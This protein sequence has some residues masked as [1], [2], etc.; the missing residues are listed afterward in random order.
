MIVGRRERF[1]IE[2]EVQEELNGWVLGRFRI[3]LCGKPIGNWDDAA[4]LS[5][6]VNWLRHFATVPQDRY[7]PSLANAPA[8]EVFRA[9]YDPVMGPGDLVAPIEDAFARFHISY[10]GMSS[11]ELFHVLLLYDVH[12]G[13]RCLWRRVGATKIE[14]CELW[15]NEMEAVAKEFCDLFD[16]EMS[17][18]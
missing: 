14:E 18:K 12:G 17:A 15:R 2:A 7:L 16:R 5:G 11:F 1:A 8:E 13:E 4:H 3:W 9:L 10:I 6:C